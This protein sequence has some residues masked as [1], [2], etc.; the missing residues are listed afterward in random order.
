MNKIGL[1]DILARSEANWNER[2]DLISAI[3]RACM[4][5]S[6]LEDAIDSVDSS[7][8]R[9][10]YNFPGDLTTHRIAKVLSK[11]SHLI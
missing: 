1:M 7:F 9:K 6:K 4:E 10:L 5:D 2:G 3:K 8:L 11:I